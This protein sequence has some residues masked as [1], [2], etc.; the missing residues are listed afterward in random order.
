[1]KPV[2]AVK[3]YIVA[4]EAPTARIGFS[5][6]LLHLA[7]PHEFHKRDISADISGDKLVVR[8]QLYS[9]KSTGSPYPTQWIMTQTDTFPPAIIR[10]KRTWRVEDC[11]V[12]GSEPPLP[13]QPLRLV[14][15]ASRSANAVATLVKFPGLTHPRPV[16]AQKRT[17]ERAA[18]NDDGD[19][20]EPAA[21]RRRVDEV[22]IPPPAPAPVTAQLPDC[23]GGEEVEEGEVAQSETVVK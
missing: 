4:N 15:T 1:M 21:K 17:L 8:V 20:T 16:L 18:V 2:Y 14:P 22:G 23:L 12:Y 5:M 19:A 9:P 13:S 6:P 11:D 3:G 10:D 7:K